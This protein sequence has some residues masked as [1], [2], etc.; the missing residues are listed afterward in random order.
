MFI[1]LI[2]YITDSKAVFL[3]YA[4][5]LPC[6]SRVIILSTSSYHCS[7]VIYNCQL[8]GCMP[9]CLAAGANLNLIKFYGM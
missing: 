6:R 5:K 4:T 3:F 9:G 8:S 2:F 7:D 1:A